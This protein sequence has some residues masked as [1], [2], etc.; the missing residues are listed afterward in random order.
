M[1]TGSATNNISENTMYTAL[2][3]NNK[4][5]KKY[6]GKINAKLLFTIREIS[7]IYLKLLTLINK[8]LLK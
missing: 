2:K 1:L 4:A 8:R 5:R 6:W 3:M 7:I